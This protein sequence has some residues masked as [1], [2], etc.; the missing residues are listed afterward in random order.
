MCIRDRGRGCSPQGG[1]LGEVLIRAHLGRHPHQGS[2]GLIRAH[3]GSSGAHQGSSGVI[4]GSSGL[5]RA[6]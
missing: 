2:S 5:I 4:R 1:E 6:H 3:Q